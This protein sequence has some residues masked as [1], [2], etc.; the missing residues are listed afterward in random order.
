MKLLEVRQ[1]Y[2][3]FGGLTAVH[4]V[5][6]D[7][8]EGELLS[9]IGPNGAGKTTTFNMIN[10][11]LRPSSGSVKLAGRELVGLAPRQ[12]ARLGVGRTFQI[13]ATFSSL[14]VLQNV[15]LGLYAHNRFIYTFF[16]DGARAYHDEALELL[17]QVG[18]ADQHDRPCSELAYGDIK[19]V[20]LAIGLANNPRLFLMDEPTAGMS[21]RERNALMALTK[22]LVVQRRMAVLFTEHSMDVV[23]NYSDRIIVLAQGKL[24]AEGNTEEIRNHQK[25]RE[26][27][28]GSGETV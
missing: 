3:H 1:L 18:M 9:L 22:K 23:F 21:P 13:A 6:F 7:L 17:E 27:Y 10:G 25:V 19:R 24:I 11:Q 15:Q 8:H 16:R 4:G 12:V 5:D 26:V 28:F 20:E 14:T 2:K